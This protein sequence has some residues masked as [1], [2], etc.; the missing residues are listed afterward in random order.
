MIRWQDNNYFL[1]YKDKEYIKFW[2][3]QLLDLNENKNFIEEII[4]IVNICIYNFGVDH[5]IG[6]LE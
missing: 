5:R 2:I 4:Y 1:N 6:K 3:Q